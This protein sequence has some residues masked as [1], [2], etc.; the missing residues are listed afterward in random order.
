MAKTLGG[1]TV[2]NFHLLQYPEP[3][4]P[5]L[6]F[7]FEGEV[8]EGELTRYTIKWNRHGY[9]PNID[10]KDMFLNM[11]TVAVESNLLELEQLTFYKFFSSSDNIAEVKQEFP[12]LW[13]IRL[14]ETRQWLFTKT[15]INNG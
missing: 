8:Q 15:I 5:L 10:R 13:A 11:E 6:P 3:R 14:E 7:I 4:H 12:R 2:E 1:H 9:C